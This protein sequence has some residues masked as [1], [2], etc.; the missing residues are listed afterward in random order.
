M[1]GNPTHSIAIA[2]KNIEHCSAA[3]DDCRE[4]IAKPNEHT[5]EDC[6]EH[7]NEQESCTTSVSFSSMLHGVIRFGSI[8]VHRPL[9]LL[10]YRLFS[11]RQVIVGAKVVHFQP[12]AFPSFAKVCLDAL[13]ACSTIDCTPMLKRG[14][15]T[16]LSTSSLVDI[17]STQS[18]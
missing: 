11:V 2:I 1:V 10:A 7:K 9:L 15:M 4:G 13:G 14:Q 8:S 18:I 17:D 5:V 12:A 6:Y 16:D 3:I